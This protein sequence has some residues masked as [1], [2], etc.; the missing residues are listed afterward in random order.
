MK[1][2]DTIA[3]FLFMYNVLRQKSNLQ[4]VIILLCMFTIQLKLM[5]WEYCIK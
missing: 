1:V 5:S 2:T 3:D 4:I